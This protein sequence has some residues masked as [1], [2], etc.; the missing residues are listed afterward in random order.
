M[1]N[2]NLENK[3]TERELY[4][5]INSNENIKQN[6]NKLTNKV[7][8]PTNIN[9]YRHIIDTHKVKD[10]DLDWVLKLRQNQDLKLSK[11]KNP[12]PPTFYQADLDD[13]IKK[14]KFPENNKKNVNLSNIEHLMY[15]RLGPSPNESQ[16]NF[17]INYLRD[18][19]NNIKKR[20]K[21]INLAYNPR[22]II[23][24]QFHRPT[25]TNLKQQ[26]LDNYMKNSWKPYQTVFKV[27]H[28]LYRLLVLKIE[29]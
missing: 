4:N 6:T 14:K 17:E 5:L 7:S 26:D 1:S 13:Y 20:N 23:S 11:L 9:E 8:Y 3:E 12:F 24:S 21:W 16:I 28:L 19:E 29:L 2:L 27:I 22:P 15:S 25:R 18:D 10:S